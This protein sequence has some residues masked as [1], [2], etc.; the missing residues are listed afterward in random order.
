MTPAPGDPPKA[1][2]LECVLSGYAERP[3]HTF[4]ARGCSWGGRSRSE[5]RTWGARSVP[6]LL[7]ARSHRMATEKGI[8]PTSGPSPDARRRGPPTGLSRLVAARVLLPHPKW[9]LPMRV[10]ACTPDTAPEGAVLPALGAADNHHISCGSGRGRRR[11]TTRR[12]HRVR[13]AGTSRWPGGAWT[14]LLT[15][16]ARAALCGRDLPGCPSETKG[17]EHGA[18]RAPGSDDLPSW[19]RS[20]PPEVRRCPC[21]ARGR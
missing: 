6:R 19:A 12:P 17:F 21:S 15:P 4:E 10:G 7:T 1:S 11:A 8:P 9:S 18:S 16:V 14:A 3:F 2:P 20:R 5:M 13:L